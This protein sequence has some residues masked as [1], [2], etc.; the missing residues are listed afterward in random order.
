[1]FDFPQERD[2]GDILEL[3]GYGQ[4]SD[5]TVSQHSPVVHCDVLRAA[6]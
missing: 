3:P 4:R 2:F 5:I 6:K 1:M